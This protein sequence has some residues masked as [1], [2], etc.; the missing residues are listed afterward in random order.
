VL[1]GHLSILRLNCPPR[2]QLKFVVARIASENTNF[3]IAARLDLKKL[4]FGAA[5]TVG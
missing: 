4:H 3:R 2:H 5:A 1:T